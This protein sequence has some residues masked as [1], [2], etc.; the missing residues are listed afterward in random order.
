MTIQELRREAGLVLH[1]NPQLRLTEITEMPFP[2][3]NQVILI[4][5]HF[6]DNDI[7]SYIQINFE[8]EKGIF[9]NEAMTNVDMQE[10]A[11][12]LIS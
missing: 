5:G 8:T 10:L 4:T 2:A 1:E 3:L 11:R 6:F 12:V 7:N 9:V